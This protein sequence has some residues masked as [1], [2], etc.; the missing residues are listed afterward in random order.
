MTSKTS[1]HLFQF[2]F[3]FP[4]PALSLQ[5]AAAALWQDGQG[6]D[7]F[8]IIVGGDAV[9]ALKAAAQAAMYHN[10]LAFRPLKTSNWLHQ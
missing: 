5:L 3:T 10:M 2:Q 7:Q 6:Q 9:E 1:L 8:E 4:G